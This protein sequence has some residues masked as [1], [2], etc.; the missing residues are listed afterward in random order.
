MDTTAFIGSH[1]GFNLGTKLMRRFREN[2]P[3]ALT[4][5]LPQMIKE[6]WRLTAKQGRVWRS[7]S[8]VCGFYWRFQFLPLNG[9]SYWRVVLT[10]PEDL[11]DDFVQAVRRIVQVSRINRLHDA[12]AESPDALELPH[13]RDQPLQHLPCRHDHAALVRAT[14]ELTRSVGIPRL[15]GIS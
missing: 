13:V 4:P 15:A 6:E 14:P 2:M 9:H 3:T 8:P 1:F 7:I 11:L 12:V 10:A 5:E